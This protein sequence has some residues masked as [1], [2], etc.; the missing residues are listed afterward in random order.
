MWINTLLS[1]GGRPPV[2]KGNP[3]TLLQHRAMKN[4]DI[5]L[6][7]FASTDGPSPGQMIYRSCP[8]R[9]LKPS[10]SYGLEV[11]Q[12]GNLKMRAETGFFISKACDGSTA[13]TLVSYGP[14]ICQNWFL[15]Q[16]L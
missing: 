8:A 1:S 12:R 16:E 7:L 6:L 14:R 5:Y 3:S 15:L 2:C 10:V 13:H 4:R 9:V 11:P